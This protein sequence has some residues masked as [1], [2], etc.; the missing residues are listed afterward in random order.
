MR[1]VRERM[2]A[3]V[4]LIVAAACSNSEAPAARGSSSPSPTPSMCVAKQVPIAF[5]CPISEI[6]S[7]RDLTAQGDNVTLN[8]TAGDGVFDPT[9]IKVKPGAKVTVTMQAG[10][11]VHDF[12]ITALNVHHTVQP[13]QKE[14]FSFTLPTT[15]PVLFYCAPHLPNG[16]QGA[17]Y[18]A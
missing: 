3:G 14:T 8:L 5:P 12:N 10:I 9:F 17:F 18:F 15:G 4:L 11:A 2:I 16:M 1:L 7:P 6:G 13:E